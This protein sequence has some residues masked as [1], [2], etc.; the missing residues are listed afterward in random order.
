[1]NVCAE[2]QRKLLGKLQQNRQRKLLGNLEE[3]EFEICSHIK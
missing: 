1:M 3:T 2:N